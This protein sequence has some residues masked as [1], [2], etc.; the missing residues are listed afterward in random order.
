MEININVEVALFA[1]TKLS[2][3]EYRLLLFV[4]SSVVLWKQIFTF[5]VERLS[6]S[7]RSLH[8]VEV[9]TMRNEIS[10]T[11]YALIEPRMVACSSDNIPNVNKELLNEELLTVMTYN[12][13]NFQQGLEW[14][15]RVKLIA[16]II[17]QVDPVMLGVQ[18]LRDDWYDGLNHQ[19]H[20]LTSLLPQ[21]PYWIY[22]PANLFINMDEG[23][24]ILS[25]YPFK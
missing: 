18:E 21:Y 5:E 14:P 23:I 6:L 2:Q 19:V 10:V 12:V 8:K 22:Q 16:D 4:P 17:T 11:G 24:A 1:A 7:S 9:T 13:W 3:D 20:D 15:E 25:K